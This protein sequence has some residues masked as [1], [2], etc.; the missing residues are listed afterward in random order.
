MMIASK[1]YLVAHMLYNSPNI[2]NKNNETL[3]MLIV[4]NSH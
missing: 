3:G 1:G 4:Y 2:V